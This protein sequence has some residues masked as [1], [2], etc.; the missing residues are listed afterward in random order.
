MNWVQRNN[1]LTLHTCFSICFST[2]AFQH[3][4][5]ICFSTST[6]QRNELGAQHDELVSEHRA[7]VAHM[8]EGMRHEVLDA[9]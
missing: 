1:F 4:L 8:I 6:F 2:S 7:A 9:K 5:F 3:L